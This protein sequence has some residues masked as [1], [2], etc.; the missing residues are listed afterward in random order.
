MW[1]GWHEFA[2]VVGQDACRANE[3]VGLVFPRKFHHGVEQLPDAEGQQATV[4]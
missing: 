2:G 3:L 4:L 1:S